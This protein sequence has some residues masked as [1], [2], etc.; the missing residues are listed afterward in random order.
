MVFGYHFIFSAYGF[1]LPNDPRG[2]WSDTIRVYDLLQFGPATKIDTTES[3]AHTKH[4][5][6]LRLKAKEALRCSAPAVLRLFMETKGGI[7]NA[8]T[9]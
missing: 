5:R 4:D 6:A 3:V 1:W 2:S 7:R 9:A 8:V